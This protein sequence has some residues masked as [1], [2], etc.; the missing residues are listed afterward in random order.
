M[1]NLL[2]VFIL[3]VFAASS[4]L[5]TDAVDIFN[6]N[7]ETWTTAVLSVARQETAATSLPN[8][9]L[10]IFAGGFSAFCI[11]LFLSRNWAKGYCFFGCI[12]VKF[13]R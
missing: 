8:D 7:S 6:V 13:R 12:H 9:G 1:V 2:C 4:G 10:A 5:T 3:G 11:S